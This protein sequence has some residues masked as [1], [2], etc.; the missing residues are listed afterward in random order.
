MTVTTGFGFYDFE[1]L[2]HE[3]FKQLC[4][5]TA[6]NS[7]HPDTPHIIHTP[8]PIEHYGTVLEDCRSFT[9]LEDTFHGIGV[10]YEQFLNEHLGLSVHGLATVDHLKG[11]AHRVID[12]RKFQAAV[13]RHGID[14]IQSS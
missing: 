3:N 10:I 2:T 7:M 13:L 1:L 8:R 4:F 6:L 9:G 12:V 14:I 5:D 11:Y